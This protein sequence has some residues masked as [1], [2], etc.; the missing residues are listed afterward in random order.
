MT[1]R[2]YIVLPN[3]YNDHWLLAGGLFLFYTKILYIVLINI[4]RY[5]IHISILDRPTYR[6]L[7]LFIYI[8]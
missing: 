3:F 4:K 2:Q 1:G 5:K 8:I 7:N 6:A